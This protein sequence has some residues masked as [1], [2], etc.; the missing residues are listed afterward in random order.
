MPPK[1]P[2][3]Y[4]E[5]FPIPLHDL[6]ALDW[7]VGLE[8]SDTAEVRMPV[9]PEALGF[10]GNLHGG[11]IATMVD[12]ACALAA[13]RSSDFD[14]F[15]QSMVTSDMHLRYLGRP[16]TDTVIAKA[17]VVKTGRQLIVVECRVVDEEDHIIAFADFSMMIVSM[18]DP[19]VPGSPTQPGAP[20]L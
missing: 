6:L 14:P 8:R 4:P 9:R 17:K 5:G 19:L 12:V 1:P 18:R 20:E 10:T 3:D 15:T 7:D 11:A 16:R 2:E 13:V